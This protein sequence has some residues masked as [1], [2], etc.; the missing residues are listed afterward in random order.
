VNLVFIGYRGTG[1]SE[2]SILAA[3]RL[4]RERIGMDT[5]L[6]ERFG[7]PIPDFVA[8]HGWDAF[9]D[10]ETALAQELSA[11]DELVIDCGGG[12]V[13][14]DD[15]ITSLRAHGRLVWLK[16]SVETIARRIGSDNQRPSLTG[17]KSFIE[18]IEE[19][20]SKRLPLYERASDFQ[21]DTDSLTVEE[22]V[23]QVVAWWHQ[24]E[25]R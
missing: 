19:V 4:G 5:T 1:K 14:R 6:V 8:R 11:R 23:G 18:E 25:A 16:A 24:Q 12:V 22:V 17:T 15:N 3:G 10:A 20:L 2:V 9:R 21:M 13:V 7:M